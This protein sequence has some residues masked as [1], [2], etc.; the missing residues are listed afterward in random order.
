[1]YRAA[2]ILC[3]Y[4]RERIQWC[5]IISEMRQMSCNNCNNIETLRCLRNLAKY[6]NVTR[7]HAMNAAKLQ[8][9]NATRCSAHGGRGAMWL[10]DEGDGDETICFEVLCYLVTEVENM[11]HCV[12]TVLHYIMRWQS[13][14]HWS[15]KDISSQSTDN[16]QP[17]RRL[18]KDL[19]IFLE[20]FP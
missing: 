16:K 10:T 14:T 6:R 19:E 9:C 8:S 1:M 20:I 13:V 7:C 15:S 18:L 3:R 2:R 5:A 12:T 11:C 4:D 17:Q